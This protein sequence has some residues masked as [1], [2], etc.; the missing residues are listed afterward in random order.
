[1]TSIMGLF[2]ISTKIFQAREWLWALPPRTHTHNHSLAWKILVLIKNLPLTLVHNRG[3]YAPY[4]ASRENIQ[5]GNVLFFSCTIEIFII[6]IIIYRKKELYIHISQ[7]WKYNLRSCTFIILYK[8]HHIYQTYTVLTV[9]S[10]IIVCME[11]D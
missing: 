2:F 10:I 11:E 3:Q 9:Y 5:G 4:L 1:M 6:Y 8:S 7:F